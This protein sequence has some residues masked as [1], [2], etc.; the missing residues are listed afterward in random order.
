MLTSAN[1]AIIASQPTILMSEFFRD[2][3]DGLSCTPKALSPKY[4]YD[5]QGSRY[6]DEICKLE[7]YY[8]FQTELRLLTHVAQ[9]LAQ[10][11]RSPAPEG[12]NVVEFGAG[13][14]HKIKP[15]LARMDVRRFTAI[16]ISGEHLQSARKTLAR[17]F[18]DLSIETIEGD[19]TKPLELGAHASVPMGF[20]PGST[21]GN[22][23]PDDA[24]AFMVSARETLGPGSYM[25]V[26][27]DTKKDESILRRAYNDIN[28]VT[29]R[30]NK[31]ILAR[32]NRELGA[33]FNLDNFEHSAWYNREQG[34]VEMHLCSTRR[35]SVSL[36]GFEFPFEQ[37]ETIHTE[38]SYK[39]HPGEF[40]VLAKRAGWRTCNGWLAD[41]AMFSMTLLCRD[42]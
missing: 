18:P 12:V 16:D 1:A 3:I 15:L 33:D 22:F 28:G 37:G 14:L 13:S 10:A 30:F 19:F 36:Q 42:A 2:V 7:E 38:N 21:I 32:I 4:F 20:F 34:R 25:L 5:T 29:A 23:V 26:G 41:D 35:H 11:F 24:V 27:V 39:Y 9:E 31:N 8:P 17:E 6:F 40:E